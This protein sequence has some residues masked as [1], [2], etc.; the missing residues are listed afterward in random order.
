MESLGPR[1]PPRK[2]QCAVC[3]EEM[4]RANFTLLFITH[5]SAT[6]VRQ[7]DTNMKGATPASPSVLDK[8]AVA[9]YV[10]HYSQ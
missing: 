2:Y 8:A 10:C 6:L 7:C 1:D 9:F 5:F 3:I 4:S